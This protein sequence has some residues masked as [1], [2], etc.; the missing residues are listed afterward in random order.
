MFFSLSK[1]GNK[2]DIIQNVSDF[3]K[4][5]GILHL[6]DIDK[7]RFKIMNTRLKILVSDKKL[8]TIE[9]KAFNPFIDA[10]CSKAVKLLKPYFN[11]IDLKH[12]DDIYYIKAQRKL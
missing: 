3:I 12:S 9:L 6:W 8:K 5:D 7:P 4:K 11:I 10:S 2:K 1:A